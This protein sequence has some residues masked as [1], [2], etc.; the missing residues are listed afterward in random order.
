MNDVKGLSCPGCPPGTT[1]EIL[2]KCSNCK[3]SYCSEHKSEDVHECVYSPE[4]V[5]DESYL[6]PR[7]KPDLI[8][9]QINHLILSTRGW[10]TLGFEPLDYAI[11]LVFVLFAGAF[12]LYLTHSIPDLD[13]I[14]LIVGIVAVYS[15]PLFF[16]R[17]V[18][19]Q[20]GTH[21]R[22]VLNQTGMILTVLTGILSFGVI[23]PGQIIPFGSSHVFQKIR[24]SSSG[25]IS[26]LSVGFALV[27]L[28]YGPFDPY[29]ISK[30]ID[31]S[32]MITFSYLIPLGYFEGRLLFTY[33]KL[34]WLLLVLG[35]VFLLVI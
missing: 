20:V 14:F 32:A 35:G 26:S 8:K 12:Q 17:Q 25:P 10:I 1:H 9:S 16:Q 11:G 21:P 30:L 4:I 2:F 24:V 6:P 23:Q 22:Y 19:L 27:L 7:I 5:S 31:Y 28:N 3:G 33:N 29:I 13:F 15:I 34:M 18:A